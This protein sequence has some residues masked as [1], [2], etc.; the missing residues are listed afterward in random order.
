MTTAAPIHQSGR[1]RNGET[2]IKTM[3]FCLSLECSQVGKAA[4]GRHRPT[5]PI[6]SLTGAAGGH[7]A[8]DGP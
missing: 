3:A 7:Q 5:L 4:L 2:F 6:S 8:F 1:G